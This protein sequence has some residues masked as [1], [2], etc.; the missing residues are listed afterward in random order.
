MAMYLETYFDAGID[1]GEDWDP[2]AEEQAQT[3]RLATELAIARKA[4][5]IPRRLG[6]TATPLELK[7]DKQFSKRYGYGAED[8]LRAWGLNEA[9]ILHLEAEAMKSMEV[10]SKGAQVDWES[11]IYVLIALLRA[12]MRRIATSALRH[13]K[14]AEGNRI[15]LRLENELNSQVQRYEKVFGNPVNLGKIPENL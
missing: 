1:P 14:I 8:L 12:E 5:S 2:A 13:G 10:I 4:E 6:Q 3:A 11:H 9:Q 15:V 7:R